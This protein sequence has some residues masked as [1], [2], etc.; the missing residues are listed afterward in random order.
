MGTPRLGTCLCGAP[1]TIRDTKAEDGRLHFMCH[2]LTPEGKAK[3]YGFVD[4][5]EAGRVDDETTR[6]NDTARRIRELGRKFHAPGLRRSLSLRC[7]GREREDRFVE[8]RLGLNQRPT[9]RPVVAS[10]RIEQGR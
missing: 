3:H 1:A 9:L 8:S 6:E 7:V 2:Q 10:Q 5:S 4:R